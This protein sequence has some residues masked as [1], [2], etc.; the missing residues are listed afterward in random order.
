MKNLQNTNRLA[1]KVLALIM[2]IMFIVPTLASCGKEEKEKKESS[3]KQEN[4]FKIDGNKLELV[5]SDLITDFDGDTD[6][7]TTWK[8]TN[9]KDEAKSP[10]FEVY[11]KFKQGDKEL[12]DVG[13]IFIDEDSYDTLSDYEVKDIEPGKTGTFFLSFKLKDKTTPIKVRLTDLFEKD[14][15]NVKIPIAD[16]KTSTVDDLQL[17][18]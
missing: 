11:Y 7:V 10:T 5:A 16:K 13:T 15:Y 14:V 18:D 4:V 1:L 17:P 3:K 12:T 6:L 2:V 8:F 9:N